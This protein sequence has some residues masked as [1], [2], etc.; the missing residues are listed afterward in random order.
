MIWKQ[1]IYGEPASKSNARIKTARGAVIKSMKAMRYLEDFR[2]QVKPPAEMF[3]E[4]VVMECTI[5]YRTQRPDLD[6]SLVMDGLQYGGV[7]KN[8]RLIRE[9]HVFHA[10]DKE[11]P[12]A[13]III[14]PRD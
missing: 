9:K 11:N 3:T 14:R 2:R 8:D 4:P 13:E 7:V 1:T 6:E 12:R 10:I 5:Y